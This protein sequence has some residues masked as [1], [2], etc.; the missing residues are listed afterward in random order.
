MEEKNVM[1]GDDVVMRAL[2]SHQCNPG[3]I[4]ARCYMWVEFVVG[5]RFAAEGFSP[6]LALVFFPQQNLTLQ[7]PIRPGP[8][9]DQLELIWLFL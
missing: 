1:S 4:P 9:C 7:I 6:C 5:S 3:Y 8:V 2:A